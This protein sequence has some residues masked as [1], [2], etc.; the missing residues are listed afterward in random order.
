MTDEDE[1]DHVTTLI[2]DGDIVMG[3]E[4][5]VKVAERKD[6]QDWESWIDQ[7]IREAQERGAFDQLPGRGRPLDLTPNPYARD[8]YLAFKILKNAGCAPEWIEL[9]KVVRGKLE[10]ALATLARRWDRRETRLSQLACRPGSE[11][12]VE[13][14]QVEASWLSAVAAFEAEVQGINR[15][16]AELN[17]KV[18]SPRF[19]RSKVD[20]CR[21]VDRLTGGSSG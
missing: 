9:D 15:E 1:S 16:I 2:W 11:S 18:P 13:R 10:A 20:P 21:E 12:E 14:Q 5:P 7:Q 3:V 19:Q 17:L 4:Q 6:R 8:Q